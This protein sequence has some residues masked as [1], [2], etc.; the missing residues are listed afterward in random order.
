[1]T[2]LSG[3]QIGQLQA[4]IVDAFTPDE[5]QQFLLTRLDKY[6]SHISLVLQRRFLD[7]ACYHIS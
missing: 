3:E 5:L 6:L 2:K 1:M 4:A 7:S